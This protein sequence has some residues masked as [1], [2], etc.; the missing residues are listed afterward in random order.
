MQSPKPDSWESILPL[1][2]STQ[3]IFK[4]Y[5]FFPLSI[6]WVLSSFFIPTTIGLVSDP[7]TIHLNY[8]NISWL[9]FPP[10]ILPYPN[11]YL[12][13]TIYSHLKLKS[14]YA[15]ASLITLQWFL[16]PK[17]VWK[18]SSQLLDRSL[19]ST[20][21]A[22]VIPLKQKS[23]LWFQASVSCC[24]LCLEHFYRFFPRQH[25]AHFVASANESTKPLWEFSPPKV[26]CPSFVLYSTL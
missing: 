5:S 23:M 4:Y 22:L 20:I 24:S 17:K 16:S 3:P 2:Q 13:S 25:G 18:P 21:E 19:S 1:C 9:I 10:L 7:L 15:T 26:K 11:L 6:Y 12:Y 8:G 14:D